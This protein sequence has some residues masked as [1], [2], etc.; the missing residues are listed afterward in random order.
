MVFDKSN[1][2]KTAAVS[3]ICG[4]ALGETKLP[5]SMVSKPMR[6]KDWMYATFFSVGIKVLM[7]CMASRGHSI[8][9][10]GSIDFKDTKTCKV[11]KCW[12]N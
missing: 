5:K 3:C 2:S 11:A 1:W 12:T 8:I 7:P 6:N 10:I 9:F 4:T